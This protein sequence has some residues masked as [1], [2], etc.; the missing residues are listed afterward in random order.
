M[1][2]ER[3]NA[4]VIRRFVDHAN[5]LEGGQLALEKGQFGF[6]R[7]SRMLVCRD[8]TGE[9]YRI[10]TEDAMLERILIKDPVQ[11]VADLPGGDTPGTFRMVL[12]KE[13]YWFK[14]ASIWVEI[15]DKGYFEG[16]LDELKEE[17]RGHVD[18]NARH[19]TPEERSEWNAKQP[20]GDYI[21]EDDPRLADS[22]T[23]LQHSHPADDINNFQVAADGGS[24][25]PTTAA[26]TSQGLIANFNWL[27]RM[28]TW[29]KAAL[30]G[31]AEASDLA[32][33]IPLTQKGAAGGVASLDSSAKIIVSQ[34]PDFIVG[35]MLHGGSFV[36]A[37]GDASLTDNAKARLGASGAAITLT[38]D[39]AAITG[40]G[41]NQSIFYIAS[42]DGSFAGKAFVTG[43]WLVGLGSKWDILENT[44]AVA[45]VNNKT[46][47]VVLNSNDIEDAAAAPAASANQIT[48]GA[49]TL[50]AA[51][52]ILI[53]NIAY[54]F[55]NKQN[56]LNRTVG[57]DDGATGTVTDTGGNISVPMQATL[58]AV[59][60]TST[61][62][63]ATTAQA[64][65]TILSAFRNNIKYLFDNKQNS[66]NTTDVTNIFNT[67]HLVYTHSGRITSPSYSGWDE[68]VNVT[69]TAN[70]RAGQ[71]VRYS[72]K[73]SI[74]VAQIKMSMNAANTTAPDN[75]P[76]SV[77]TIP[78]DCLITWGSVANAEGAR[79]L[80]PNKG[81]ANTIPAWNTSRQLTLLYYSV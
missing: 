73:N 38:N 8:V 61:Q 23:P 26:G 28:I 18:D 58:P 72:E 71:I 16:F 43:D 6:A 27:R 52:T 68:A 33:Y 57:S 74:N 21:E 24:L 30:A 79:V 5:Q 44:D 17:L 51:L 66:L 53:D 67:N 49:R 22:R 11:T 32:S 19:I 12:E 15:P 7:Q 48:A 77:S 75:F 14:T 1:P 41:A 42:A 31:K 4:I 60:A 65:R 81:Q 45:S 10:K 55:T 25:E 78:N 47:A 63:T 62:N 56:S 50:R 36:P 69:D 76:T 39:N 59:A 46:G 64:V 13:S 70:S 29:L 80:R 3:E 35:Q 40:Y 20:P 34:L 54:L 9:F 2:I 37:T